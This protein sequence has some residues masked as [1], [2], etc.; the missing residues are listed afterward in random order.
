MSVRPPTASERDSIS[1]TKSLWS[2]SSTQKSFFI[3][4]LSLPYRQMD[5]SALEESR[6]P[7]TV[8]LLS[9]LFFL[10]IASTKRKSR[11]SYKT[12]FSFLHEL[13]I[14][15]VKIFD[16]TLKNV[17]T[18]NKINQGTGRSQTENK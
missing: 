14:L 4:S 13:F 16:L 7:L 2:F 12:F 11:L 9:L 10:F 6:G 17:Y 1:Q 3:E 8:H 15:P 18:E 5:S